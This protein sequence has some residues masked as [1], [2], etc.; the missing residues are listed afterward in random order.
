MWEQRNRG[1]GWRRKGRK[2]EKEKQRRKLLSIGG[3]PSDV[4]V[5]LKGK[6]CVYS[7]IHY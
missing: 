2:K 5:Y 4:D 1:G 3:Q 7:G 6:G